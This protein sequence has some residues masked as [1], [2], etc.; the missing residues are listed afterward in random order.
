[1]S[2]ERLYKDKRSVIKD[3]HGVGTENYRPSLKRQKQNTRDLFLTEPHIA[4]DGFRLTMYVKM[5]PGSFIARSLA[6]GLHLYHHTQF[7]EVFP[8]KLR[9]LYMLGRHCIP[10]LE[11][12]INGNYSVHGSENT[13][14]VMTN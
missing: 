13:I 14:A 6:Q 8:I 12:Q 7:Y 10:R 4:Q 3:I 1:M 5:A 11:T 2:L 9:A